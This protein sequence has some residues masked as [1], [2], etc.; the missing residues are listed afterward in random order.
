MGACQSISSDDVVVVNSAPDKRSQKLIMHKKTLGGGSGSTTATSTSHDISR[1]NSSDE[2]KDD[3]KNNCNDKTKKA[4]KRTSSR[5]GLDAMIKERREQGHLVSNV[6]NIESRGTSTER[7]IQDVYEGVHDGKILGEGV[8]GLVRVVRHR[9][10]GLPYAVKILN[11]H[12]LAARRGQSA[13]QDSTEFVVRQEEALRNEISIMSQLDHPHI[14]RL[15]E[16]YEDDENIYLVQ[17]ICSGGELFDFLDEQPDYYM[18]EGD[19]LRCVWQMLSA[20]RYLHSKGV[21]HRDLKL[22]NFLFCTTKHLQLKMIGTC[23]Q[24]TENA[25]YY[26]HT[27]PSNNRI[28]FFNRCWQTLVT[29]STLTILLQASVC[30]IWLEHPTPLHPK[31]FEE[32]MTRSVMYGQLASWLTCCSVGILHLEDVVDQNLLAKYAPTY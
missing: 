28:S 27:V 18:N 20:L 13:G 32:T 23:W 1:C 31:S 8:A 10:T 24:R 22:E 2:A 19:A 3:P 11:L 5:V 12:R 25:Y 9:A 26:S 29:A 6:V 17:E 4:M 7:T 16:V 30:T 14:A 15:Q 21:V